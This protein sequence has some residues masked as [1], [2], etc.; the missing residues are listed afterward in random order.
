MAAKSKSESS[1]PAV[2]FWPEN[3][4]E[5]DR[6]MLRFT[7]PVRGAEIPKV[8]VGDKTL[9][10]PM[11][12]DP[13]TLIGHVPADKPGKKEV[14]IGGTGRAG[15][16][17][18]SPL[19]HEGQR[20][21]PKG[22][23]VWRAIKHH[24]PIDTGAG[25]TSPPFGGGKPG[26]PTRPGSGWYMLGANYYHDANAKMPTNI[27]LA[28]LWQR[29]APDPMTFWY[30]EPVLSENTL[31]LAPMTSNGQEVL[32]AVDVSTGANLWTWNSPTV[33]LQS[34]IDSAPLCVNGRVYVAQLFNSSAMPGE[35]RVV[36]GDAGNGS[37]LW[38]KPVLSSAW[39]SYVRLNAAY[40]L[41]YV[42]TNDGSIRALDALTGTPVWQQ[43][44]A[45]PLTPNVGSDQSMTVA[46]GSVIVGG[47]NGLRAYDPL[48]GTPKWISP[49]AFNCSFSPI[50]ATTGGNPPL[51]VAGD[52]AG[53]IH[54]FN[55]FT[56]AYIWSYQGENTLW[57]PRMACDFDRLYLMQNRTLKALDLATGAL[58]GTSPDLGGDTTGAPT[59]CAN[60]VFQTVAAS[61]LNPTGAS[62]LIAFH[63]TNVTTIV[64]QL[65]VNNTSIARPV[66]EGKQLYLNVSTGVASTAFHNVIQ[67]VRVHT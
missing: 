6:I 51:I 11:L 59:V 7:Q 48:D 53:T 46:F 1:P 41:I 35:I 45:V 64:E 16:A 29:T 31:F 50:V 9:D 38:E 67:A 14:R 28:G 66:I 60:R 39:F 24:K 3:A 15:F 22:D 65:A 27:P 10:A 40:G 62:S 13:Y 43:I 26:D 49:L 42:M 57:W 54:A 44:A 33:P 52:P 58:L 20:P 19:L 4:S 5:G 21:L 8:T 34:R 63:P 30:A 56:S 17:A 47:T 12:L 25:G 37:I 55:A 2:S 23:Y 36:C 18:E 61:M 32:A